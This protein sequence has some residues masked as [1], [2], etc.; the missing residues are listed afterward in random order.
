MCGTAL[1]TQVRAGPHNEIVAGLGTL[2]LFTRMK[3]SLHLRFCGS[4][5][6]ENVTLNLGAPAS[7]SLNI[8]SMALL[9]GPGR[10]HH[11]SK[12]EPP[13]TSRPNGTRLPGHGADLT[14]DHSI[15]PT[16]MD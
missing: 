9:F 14:V 4:G 2:E 8:S 10:P 6:D 5:S 7:A 3:I 12:V 1:A 11:H 16:E 15:S 13:F